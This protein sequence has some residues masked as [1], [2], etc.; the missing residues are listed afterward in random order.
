[1]PLILIYCSFALAALQIAKCLTCICDSLRTKLESFF[2]K[3]D[4]ILERM[5]LDQVQ[6]KEKLR[7]ECNDRVTAIT[8]ELQ[9][10][11]E[12]AAR[13]QRKLEDDLQVLQHSFDAMRTFHT[14]CCKRVDRV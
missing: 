7:A 8:H 6:F 1:M 5:S 4:A 12:E 14:R 2:R 13:N 9:T 11:R 10:I 3:L